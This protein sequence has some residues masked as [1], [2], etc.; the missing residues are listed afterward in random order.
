M[1]TDRVLEFVR[2]QELL[3][4]GGRVCCAVSGGAD[5]TAMLLCLLELKKLLGLQEITAV[6]FNHHLRGEESNRDEA[7]V[8][9]L[10]R[11][12]AVPCL[13]DGAEVFQEAR[14]RGRGVEE[15]ARNLRYEFFESAV[16]PGTALATAH[17]ADDN[18][19]TILQHLIRG[20]GLKGLCGIPPRR[21]RIVRPLLSATREEIRAYLESRGQSWVEDS[22]NGEDL[23]FRNR[24]RRQ[25]LPLLTAENPALPRLAG[26]N[27][28]LLRDDLEYLEA[29][30]LEKMDLAERRG[31]QLSMECSELQAM[32]PALRRRVLRNMA[33][34][35]G[36][37]LPTARQLTALE[38]LC[39]RTEGSG[40]LSLG[41]VQVCREYG[42]LTF[43][44][45]RSSDCPWERPLRLGETIRTPD[46]EW[47]VSCDA[48]APGEKIFQSV[49]TF[50]LNCDII[51]GDLVVRT[52]KT[53][54]KI[55][56][57]G[58][59]GTKSLKKLLIDEK[60][61]VSL[62]D[63]LPLLADSRGVAAVAGFGVGAGYA[64]NSTGRAL[65]IHMKRTR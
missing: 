52:R 11:R 63:R 62:R 34:E 12:L 43:G 64:A 7:F 31:E 13:L 38:R 5:S 36:G 3:A 21:G 51:V 61:P 16:P 58:R 53:G 28:L 60:I 2:E 29:Q 22:S 14:R 46:G 8:R 49:H 27:A 47:E 45:T 25:V 4:P 56:I 23:Y 35:A 18:L 20:A 65:K 30:A 24:L 41:G 26:R 59:N 33:A 40:A 37:K 6:H 39:S 48:P 9:E 57:L 1:M 42:T 19:E 17:T 44:R 32:P 10:C 55:N 15:T 50:Y 54:D